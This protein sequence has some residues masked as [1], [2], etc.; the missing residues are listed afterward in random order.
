MVSEYVPICVTG[1]RY[2]VPA[3]LTIMAALEWVGFRLV[4]SCGC[5]GGFCGACGT[6]YRLPGSPK[7]YTALACQAKIEPGMDI[8]Q[9]PSFPVTRPT[10][11]LTNMG[12]P[13][14]EVLRLFPEVRRCLGC[15]TCTK[16]CPQ[17]LEPIEFIAGALRGDF[18]RVADL[19]FECVMCGL[20]AVRCPAEIAPYQVA[21]FIRRVVGRIRRP[22]PQYLVERVSEVR[23][24]KYGAEVTQL[25]EMSIDQLKELYRKR[26]IEP[27]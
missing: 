7:L 4:R 2:E 15:N 3:E 24:G 25:A 16:A 18:E 12:D 8:V 27:L 5:R 23:A 1:N 21:L 26:D 19:S 14:R 9:V 17:E 13:D 10:Y 20:C 6:F 11:D 22:K